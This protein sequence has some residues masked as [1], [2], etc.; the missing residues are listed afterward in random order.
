[1]TSTGN[2][3]KSSSKRKLSK[4]TIN[5]SPSKITSLRSL[6]GKK[7]ESVR[8]KYEILEKR[9]NLIKLMLYGREKSLIYDIVK[10]TLENMCSEKEFYLRKLENQISIYEK[11]DGKKV[12]IEKMIKKYRRSAAD[13]EKSLPHELRTDKC[14][15]M[16]LNYLMSN[17][18][19][20]KNCTTKTLSRWY[21]FM[22]DRTRSIRKDL[23]Q[24][25]IVNKESLYI[26]EVCARFHI[27]MA[28]NLHHLSMDEFD[29]KLN[30]EQLKQCL[31][32]IFL[33]YKEMEN[34]GIKCENE[35]E[36]RC[37]ELIVNFHN[38]NI[39]S[40]IRS[41]KKEIYQSN[42]YRKVIKLT[43]QFHHGNYTKFFELLKE[44]ENPLILCLCHQYF[45]EVRYNAI[46]VIKIAYNKTKIPLNYL[47]EILCI[48]EKDEL[49]VFGT[50]CGLETV[51][52]DDNLFLVKNNVVPKCK[53]VNIK[54]N[55]IKSKLVDP[56][57]NIVKISKLDDSTTF[58]SVP[59]SFDNLN[60]YTN[61]PIFH[62][63]TNNC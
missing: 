57:E 21:D 13:Q 33:C 63:Y 56:L 45:F 16:T 11:D 58:N 42:E 4:N 53:V 15:V 37:Y 36:F 50:G 49:V 51:E 52:N 26:F 32:S 29:P 7:C 20:E 47:A 44:I 8:E 27:Y 43:Q 5:E 40:K 1:M 14:L 12:N 48:E 54:D 23:M 61:D 3:S 24:Q 60:R 59:I 18:K 41:F 55:W 9:D 10:G 25:D 30:F 62:F 35:K 39:L 19:P 34:D 38:K 28:Y 46:N 17:V 22:W 2:S 31:T 6:Y